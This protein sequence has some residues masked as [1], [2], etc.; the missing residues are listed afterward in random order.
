MATSTSP[1]RAGPSYETEEHGHGWVLFAGTMLMIAGAL[2]FIYGIAAV[3]NSKFFI[4]DAKY[5]I[6]DLKTYGWILLILGAIQFFAAFSIWNGTEWGRWV[7]VASAGL[8]AIFQ[9]LAI[10]GAPFLSVTLF[11]VD[12]LIIYGLVAYGGRRAT[13]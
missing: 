2:N 7:G 10:N 11:A 9:L 1:R 6:T 12:V 8:N 13:A 3:S 5:V 4:G